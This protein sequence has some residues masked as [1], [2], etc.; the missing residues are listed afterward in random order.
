MGA[1]FAGALTSP[2]SAAA[3]VLRFLSYAATLVTA[4]GML[5]VVVV[6]DRR[7]GD[8]P[9]LG[10][11]VT[12]FAAVAVIATLGGLALQA[13]VLTGRGPATLADADVLAAIV[14]STFG[15]SAV[16]RVV[17]LA[18]VAGAVT[19]AWRSW[20]LALGLG[21]ALAA[22]GSFLLTGH[23]V[24]AEPLWGA[25]TSALTHTVAAAAWFGGLVFLAM[26]LRAR[27]GDG[28]AAGRAALVARFSAMATI[29]VIAVSIAGA[30]RVPTVMRV[31]AAAVDTAYGAA[32]ALKVV[33][34]T[35][36]F[37]VAGY[38][39]RRLVPAIRSAQ[40]GAEQRL[41]TTIRIEAVVLVVVIVL[42]A[43][44]ADLSPPGP[45]SA[46]SVSG[47][48]LGQQPLVEVAR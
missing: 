41:R 34:V 26:T 35:L 18:V 17:A 21:A 32:L 2:L 5:F 22:S 1:E 30:V 24:E 13:A 31:D 46:T 20:A 19:F 33:L 10:R 12:L 14:E 16:V 27:A 39:H 4:G 47:L 43:L 36:V 8:R 25:V 38:N 7:V 3:A 15:T 40:G 48:E 44:L 45:P 9:R 37:V 23:T 6:A 29:A 28:D 42:S 11:G